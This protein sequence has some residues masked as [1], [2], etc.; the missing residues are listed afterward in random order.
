MGS[1]DG[2][3]PSQAKDARYTRPRHV[4]DDAKDSFDKDTRFYYNTKSIQFKDRF[5]TFCDTRPRHSKDR[6]VKTFPESRTSHDG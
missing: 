4:Q 3:K 2:I 1:I 5:D 6:C